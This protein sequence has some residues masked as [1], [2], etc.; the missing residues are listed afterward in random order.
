MHESLRVRFGAL[1]LA[2]SLLLV[3]AVATAASAAPAPVPDWKLLT[4]ATSPPA[5]EFNLMAYDPAAG[6]MV[7]VQ[8]REAV[9]QT[10]QTWTY[11]PAAETW[12]RQITTTEPPARVHG[13]IAYDPR[14]EEVVLFG[15]S[16]EEGAGQTWTWDGTEWTHRTPATSPPTVLGVMAYDPDTGQ[17]VLFGQTA[18]METWI[19]DGSDWAQATPAHRPNGRIGESMAFDP[20]T[21]RLLLHGG[22]STGPPGVFNDTWTWDGSEWTELTPS[23]SAPISAG[24]SMAYDPEIGKMVLVT[25]FGGEETSAVWTWDGAE[26]THSPTATSLPE[27][28]GEALAFDPRVGHLLLFG[29]AD[30]HAVPHNETWTYG[31]PPIPTL[32]ITASPSVELGGSIAATANLGGGHEPSGSIVFRLYGPDDLTCAGAALA[33]WSV[34]V[35]GPGTYPTPSP[36]TPT[37]SGTYR[38]T[39]TYSGDTVNVAAEAGCGA[40]GNS[41]VV[42]AKAVTPLGPPKDEAKPI[43]PPPAAPM[44]MPSVSVSYSPNHSHA[45][46]RKGGPR[47]TFRFADQA[48]GVTFYCRLDKGSFKPCKSPT[49]Y[50]HLKRGRHVFAVK[51]ID[52]A[53][54]ESATKRV[55]FFVGRR[56]H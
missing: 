7:L 36:F 44:P 32:G 18:A 16:A 12:T 48:P 30:I 19:W 27:R 14:S 41:V 29:G 55:S 6:Q 51:S 15:G 20:A 49:V 21:G 11:D 26:W 22:F 50:R 4:P 39:A 52:A 43:S 10:A 13:A 5:S 56:R 34:S 47:W 40:S 37:A 31:L 17:M 25:P 24:G 23:P 33:E 8:G 54:H 28:S 1:L 35:A 38:F 45:S 53:G 42:T 9:G 3:L 2:S 46:N